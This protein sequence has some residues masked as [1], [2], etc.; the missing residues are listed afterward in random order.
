MNARP[1]PEKVGIPMSEL[2]ANMCRF[3][4]NDAEKGEE[5]LFCGAPS[6]GAWCDRHRQI[7]Y[8]RRE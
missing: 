8:T 7:V 6:D 3:A 5:H 4:I 1:E 2:A